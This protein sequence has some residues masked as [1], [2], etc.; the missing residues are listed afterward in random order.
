[1]L[2]LFNIIKKMHGKMIICY[3]IILGP[4]VFDT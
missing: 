2:M 1:M 4:R 3:I